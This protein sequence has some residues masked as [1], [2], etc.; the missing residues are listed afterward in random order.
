M[1]QRPGISTGTCAAAAAK[2]AALALRGERVDV[3]D[4]PL[5][6]GERLSV[7]VVRAERLAEDRAIG[8]VV[9]D[10]GDDVDVTDGLLV[11]VELTLGGEGLRFRAGDGVGVVTLPGLQLAVGEPAINPVPRE[12]MAAALIEALGAEPACE[13]VVSIEGGEE[14]A[15]KT[16]NPRLGVV[17]GLSV[18]GTTGIVQPKSDEAWA[19]SL[20]PQLDVAVAAGYRD[21]WLVPGGLGERVAIERFEAPERA[22]VQTANF[23]GTLLDACA[24]AGVERAV[25]VGHVGKLAKVAAGLFDTHSR[26]GDARLETIAALAAAEGAPAPLVARLLALQTAQAAVPL[27]AETGLAGTWDALA[28]R[29]A[30]RASARAGVPVACA[31][32]GYDDEVLGATHE[33]RERLQRERNEGRA[34]LWVV[35]VGP[36]DEALLTP[37]AWRAIRD[38]E[39]LVGGARQLDAFAPEGVERVVLGADVEA[40]FAQVRER[41]AEG[42]CVTVLASGDPGCFGVL[43][44]T[45]RLLPEWTPEVVPGVSSVQL[46]AARLGERWD[47]AAL[48]SAH[49]RGVG[50]VVDAVRRSSRVFALADRDVSPQEIASALVAAGLGDARLAVCERLGLADE[51]ITYGACAEIASAGGTCDHTSDTADHTT[52]RTFDG[53]SVVFIER[54]DPNA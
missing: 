4:V 29:A 19:R 23:V 9:K 27:L 38:A 18:L 28:E 53:L 40:A 52:R 33:L 32:L 31:V 37:A 47:D 16:F 10:A 25:L 49:G 5:P 43:A 41:L 21:V 42:R 35:G 15:A 36:G 22:V 46:A 26:V 11:A 17:G 2:A 45:R 54:E 3:V 1:S 20:V 48:A 39:V 14:A 51:R 50:G 24:A 12:Q 30:A 7:A 6:G 8:A 13:V 34:R 44:T